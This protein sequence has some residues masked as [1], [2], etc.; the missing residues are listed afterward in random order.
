MK[1]VLARTLIALSAVLL[2]NGCEGKRLYRVVGECVWEGVPIE[3]GVINFFP[4]DRDIHPTTARITKG[5]FDA[6]VPA[7]TM[8]VEVHGQKDMGFNKFMNQNT[9]EH[10][11]SEE[12]S[13]D[14]TVLRIEVEK[15]DNNVANFI[16][17]LAK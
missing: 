3:N 10:F 11:V 13:S 15:H 4:E 17:P 16:L 7:G 9:F 5:R 12:Y 1:I 2:L 14:K 8:K 6:L